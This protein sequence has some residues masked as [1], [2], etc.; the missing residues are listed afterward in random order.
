MKRFLT[1]LLLAFSF[2]IQAT[3]TDPSG[4]E[5]VVTNEDGVLLRI[6][7]EWLAAEGLQAS[8]MGIYLLVNSEWMTLEE[9]LETPECRRKSWVCTRCKYRNYDGIN[10]CAV[11]GKPRYG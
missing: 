8:G 11:C 5:E 7:D 2:T 3:E 6:G 4:I 1:V 9:A 10:N